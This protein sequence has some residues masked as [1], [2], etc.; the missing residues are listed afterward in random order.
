[1]FGLEAGEGDAD[2]VR[3]GRA[4]GLQIARLLVGDGHV[5]GIAVVG[6]T[7]EQ[8]TAGTTRREDGRGFGLTGVAVENVFEQIAQAVA[9]RIDGDERQPD[10][11]L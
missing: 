4:P 9:I 11:R 7:Q 3:R 6:K 5:G 2:D 8:V 10:Q 1:M